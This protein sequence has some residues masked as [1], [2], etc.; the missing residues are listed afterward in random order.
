MAKR[1]IEDVEKS[2]NGLND[3]FLS[4]KLIEESETLKKFDGKLK[5][6]HF[7]GKIDNVNCEY[8]I[9]DIGNRRIIMNRKFKEEIDKEI[10]KQL[11]ENWV[12]SH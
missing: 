5:S 11:K 9:E 6:I 8:F 3:K 12:Q 7:C 10:I 1:I 2:L 4:F